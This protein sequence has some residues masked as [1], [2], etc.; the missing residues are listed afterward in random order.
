MR[1]LF[2]YPNSYLTTS[3]PLGIAYMSAVLKDAGHSVECFDTTFYKTGEAQNIK[4]QKLGQTGTAIDYSLFDVVIKDES[5]LYTDFEK[6]IRRFNPDLIAFSVVEEAWFLTKKLIPFCGN[7]TVIVGGVFP[8]FAY[9]KVKDSFP[10]ITMCIGEGEEWILNYINSVGNLCLDL[11]DINKL[12]FPDYDIF[13]TLMQYRPMEGGLKKTLMIETQR[14]CPYNCNFCNSKAQK[15]LYGKNFYRRK[16]IDKIDIELKYL[17]NKHSPEFVYW[18]GDSFLSMPEIEWQQFK[19]MYM[20]YR[21]PFWMNTRPETITRPRVQD[22]KE[23]GCIRCN[24]G[25]EHGD[26]SFRHRMVNRIISNETIINA[27]RCF[28][29]S[30]INLIVNN[31]IGYPG[32]TRNQLQATIDLCGKIKEHIH[33]ASAFIFTPYHGTELRKYA[34]ENNYLD[35]RIICSNIWSGSLLKNQNINNEE[36]S[37][38]QGNFNEIIMA[39]NS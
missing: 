35:D 20:K 12:P 5:D 6:R 3:I 34:I 28:K 25:I 15:D 24:L 18:V 19:S 14:G 11:T 30:G 9:D 26:E 4:K 8:T 39:A 16:S 22:L 13:D 33:S 23:M 21:L 7:Y 10:N 29:N 17:I 38:I 1:I 31:I 2:V 32:E 27:A 37:N 36:L